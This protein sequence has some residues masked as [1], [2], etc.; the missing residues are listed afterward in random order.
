[1]VC[2]HCNDHLE[3]KRSDAV[4][5]GKDLSALP[6]PMGPS[7]SAG[8]N[9]TMFIILIVILVLGAGIAAYFVAPLAY[10][11][12]KN[13]LKSRVPVHHNI[14]TP[15]PEETPAP[16]A[17]PEPSPT[18]EPA[19]SP[20]PT[21][22]PT[23]TPTPESTPTPTAGPTPTPGAAWTLPSTNTNFPNI[24]KL[25]DGTT[26]YDVTVLEVQADRVIIGHRDGVVTLECSTLTDDLQKLLNYSPV[27]AGTAKATRAIE[28]IDRSLIT[29]TPLPS[30]TPTAPPQ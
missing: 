15:E 14:P 4:F 19:T 10:D 17:T 24:W 27:V 6:S 1:M 30:T 21:A 9:S 13:F 22:A 5:E 26:Y 16:L 25:K 7:G 12:Y 23:P 18:P 28:K 29:P 3:E 8:G 20:A 11:A 2:V